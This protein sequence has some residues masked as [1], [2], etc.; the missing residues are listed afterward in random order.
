MIF[1]LICTEGQVSEPSYLRT[2]SD[3][4]SG[5]RPTSISTNV[6][7]LP[8]PLG[9]NQGHVK[10]V[11]AANTAIEVHCKKQDSI[12]SIADDNDSIERWLIVDYDDMDS[13]NIDISSLRQ[14]AQDNGYTLVVNKPNF[15]FFVLAHFLEPNAIATIRPNR[16]ISNIDT[17]TTRLNNTNRRGRG[18]TRA[19]FMP[20]Y[21]KNKHAANKF[22]GLLLH[23]HPELI[24][25]MKNFEVN[26]DETRYTEMPLIINR[27]IDIYS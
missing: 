27:I 15:E 14:E 19:M 13:H 16:Y 7:I 25:R 1:V 11:K 2:L 8:I 12:L 22:F 26:I 9:G 5:Q 17:H 10:L 18:F 4:V 20:P 23:Y 24:E 3:V 6:E 21:S